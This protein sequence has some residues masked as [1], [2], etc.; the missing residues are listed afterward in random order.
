MHQA[1]FENIRQEKDHPDRDGDQT[2]ERELSIDGET[3]SHIRQ[4]H[5]RLADW[6]ESNR[7]NMVP[8]SVVGQRKHDSIGVVALVDVA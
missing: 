6:K 2:A 8:P 5:P 4:T 7:S 1:P 3:P